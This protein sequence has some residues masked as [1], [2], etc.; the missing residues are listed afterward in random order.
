MYVITFT[1][2]LVHVLVHVLVCVCVCRTY[3]RCEMSEKSPSRRW[4]SPYPAPQH[5]HP[6]IL[7]RKNPGP[8]TR[9]SPF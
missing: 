2:V 6:C 5:R 7:S 4:I 3:L 9:C 1:C 8:A